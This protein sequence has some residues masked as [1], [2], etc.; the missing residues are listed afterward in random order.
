[1]DCWCTSRTRDSLYCTAPGKDSLVSATPVA[2][3]DW[4]VDGYGGG[5]GEDSDS[6]GG[7]LRWP[8]RQ[9]RTS[10][11]W[12]R[13]R[14][15]A[16]A[17]DVMGGFN[18]SAGGAQTQS[19]HRE[20]APRNGY[21]PR[22][23]RTRLRTRRCEPNQSSR[24]SVPCARAGGCRLCTCWVRAVPRCWWAARPG[25]G[26]SQSGLCACAD[27]HGRRGAAACGAETASIVYSRR[28]RETSTGD[29]TLALARRCLTHPPPAIGGDGH[30]SVLYLKTGTPGV[31]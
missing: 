29:S 14:V 22:D 25:V 1:M 23:S 11:I 12:P 13:G 20:R 8:C 10:S 21:I 4:Q 7:G 19:L 2:G 26:Q 27:H 9:A 24:L 6:D 16:V 17:G 18:A 5:D 31:A 15:L 28:T 30:R 3:S